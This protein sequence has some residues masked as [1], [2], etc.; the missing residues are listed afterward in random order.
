MDPNCENAERIDCSVE[1]G[2]MPATKIPRFRRLLLS[3][4]S[5]TDS[6]DSDDAPSFLLFRIA[7]LAMT[8]FA[9]AGDENDST[10]WRDANN[11]NAIIVT[12]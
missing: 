9:D 11:D 4:S 2:D 12:R 8:A 6:D 5:S 10:N 3:D 7:L 1:V